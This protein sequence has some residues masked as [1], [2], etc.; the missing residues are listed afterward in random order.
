MSECSVCGKPASKACS[1]CKKERY[2]S[3]ECQVNGWKKHKKVCSTLFH[4]KNVT[5]TKPKRGIP[6]N[7]ITFKA[8]DNPIVGS[9]EEDDVHIWVSHVQSKVNKPEGKDEIRLIT[10]KILV[11]NFNKGT[12]KLTSK[13]PLLTLKDKL[14]REKVYNGEKA[15]FIEVDGTNPS[16]TTQVVLEEGHFAVMVLSFQINKEEGEE[17]QKEPLTKCNFLEVPIKVE[18]KGVL[19]IKVDFQ[20]NNNNKLQQPTEKTKSDVQDFGMVD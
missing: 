3:R 16:N 11:L 1:K 10:F 12:A 13:S 18:G 9:G 7:T 20:N 17:E 19:K 2:C 4:E 14:I 6:K 8:Q 5:I 15:D